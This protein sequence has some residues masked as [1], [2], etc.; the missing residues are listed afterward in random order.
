MCSSDLIDWRGAWVGPAFLQL[1]VP[2]MFCALAA[3]LE[4]LSLPAHF[5]TLD[6]ITCKEAERFYN[7]AVLDYLKP[8]HCRTLLNYQLWLS[9][10][11]RKIWHRRLGERDFYLSGKFLSVRLQ[12]LT[13]VILERSSSRS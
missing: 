10:V 6:A 8:L 7:E 11:N 3:G 9:I 12:L 5:E 2:V 13:I 4:A 1:S